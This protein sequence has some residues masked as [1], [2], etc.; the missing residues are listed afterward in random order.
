MVSTCNDDLLAALSTI[1]EFSSFLAVCF[2]TYSLPSVACYNVVI[3][4][5]IAVDSVAP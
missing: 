1:A 3:S 5:Y 2:S 4:C